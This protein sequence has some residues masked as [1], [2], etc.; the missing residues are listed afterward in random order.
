MLCCP[1]ERIPVCSLPHQFLSFKQV[2]NSKHSWQETKAN[3]PKPTHVKT[4]GNSQSSHKTTNSC[5]TCPSP[6]Q[7]IQHN[8]VVKGLLSSKNVLFRYTDT[9]IAMCMHANCKHI[10]SPLSSCYWLM[11]LVRGRLSGRHSAQLN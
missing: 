2:V 7:H 4:S 5:T 3:K 1:L 10:Q 11:K 9:Y 8:D 6:I